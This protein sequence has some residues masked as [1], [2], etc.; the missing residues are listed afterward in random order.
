MCLRNGLWWIMIPKATTSI[1]YLLLIVV[2]TVFVMAQTPQQVKGLMGGIIV[3][4]LI[5]YGTIGRW[6]IYSDIFLSIFPYYP[7]Q[8]LTKWFYG[9]MV[10]AAIIF[11]AFILFVFIS[12]RYQLR[13]RDD[14]IPY[15]MFAENYF[16][17]NYHREREYL[18]IGRMQFFN[19]RSVHRAHLRT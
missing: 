8:G 9:N 7:K 16:E 4:S 13:K 3:S 1:G 10:F 19:Y 15:H 18:A 2:L 17:N 6:G 12:K 5:I 14:V 11:I